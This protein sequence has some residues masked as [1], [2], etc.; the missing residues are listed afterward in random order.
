[1]TLC[2]AVALAGWL[3]VS[4]ALLGCAS[5]PSIEEL[6]VGDCLTVRGTADRP[7]AVEAPCGS[8][9]STYRVV[10]KVENSDECPSD[11]D[12]SY[13]ARAGFGSSTSTACVDIDWVVGGCMSVDP[14]GGDD[15]VRVECDDTSVHNRQRATQILTGVA[16]VDQC[17]SGLGYAYDERQ[18]TVCVEAVT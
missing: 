14:D 4:C 15:P 5:A 2:G 11:A 6:Q 18:F 12:S 9:E 3:A 1:M 8:L 13:T 10:A 16:S 7:E 17:A